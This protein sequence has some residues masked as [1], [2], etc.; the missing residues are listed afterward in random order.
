MVFNRLLHTISQRHQ[1]QWLFFQWQACH[2]FDLPIV[3]SSDGTGAK[4][5]GLNLE[6]DILG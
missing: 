3:K 5:Q 6:I 2:L 4:T 1:I